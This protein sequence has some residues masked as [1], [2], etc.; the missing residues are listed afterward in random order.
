[1]VVDTSLANENVPSP[2]SHMAIMRKSYADRVAN[3][4]EQMEAMKAGRFDLATAIT[5]N[6]NDQNKAADPPTRA[7]SANVAKQESNVAVKAE[8]P[9]K[10]LLETLTG[11][12]TPETRF[13]ARMA[14]QCA[15]AIAG[16]FDKAWQP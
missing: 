8:A 6:Q 11:N 14:L 2:R 1:M 9:L 7:T 12:Y 10:E 5:P 15:E 16:R 4:R 3:L 13:P